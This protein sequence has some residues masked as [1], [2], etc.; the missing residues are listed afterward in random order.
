MN[1]VK[2]LH[3][4]RSAITEIAE[5]L[6]SDLIFTAEKVLR[7]QDLIDGHRDGSDVSDHQ[8]SDISLSGQQL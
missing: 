8:P 2:I 6:V 4:V 1:R 7:T 5:L 3:A